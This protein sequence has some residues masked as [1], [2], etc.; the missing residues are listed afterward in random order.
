M[1]LSAIVRAD[2]IEIST[3]RVDDAIWTSSEVQI[4]ALLAAKGMDALVKTWT[5]EAGEIEMSCDSLGAVESWIVT[6]NADED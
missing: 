5:V 1:I 4:R 2:G 6:L 3:V